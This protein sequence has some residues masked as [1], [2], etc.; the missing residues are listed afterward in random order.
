MYRISAPDN[1]AISFHKSRLPTGQR[2]YYFD[3]SRMEHIFLDPDEGF[4]GLR[5]MAELAIELEQ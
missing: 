2:I 5:E 4:P 3:W 1:W